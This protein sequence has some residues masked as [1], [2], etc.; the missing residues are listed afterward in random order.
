[1]HWIWDASL[2]LSF[3]FQSNDSCCILSKKRVSALVGSL[4][5]SASPPSPL[6]SRSSV[7]AVTNWMTLWKN[8]RSLGPPRLLPPLRQRS[9]HYA[10]SIL[11][12][13]F[14]PFIYIFFKGRLLILRAHFRVQTACEQFPSYT[15]IHRLMYSSFSI[16]KKTLCNRAVGFLYHS[17]TDEGWLK[18]NYLITKLELANS[19]LFPKRRFIQ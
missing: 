12:C 18:N 6:A 17:H 9:V 19:L 16:L 4:F 13:F 2:S 10:T 15:S 1:M 14:L 5:L 11:S 7:S 8:S 3:S